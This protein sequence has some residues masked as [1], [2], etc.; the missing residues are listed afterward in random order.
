MRRV[1]AETRAGGVL[2]SSVDMLTQH[3]P[4]SEPPSAMLPDC[5]QTALERP[6]QPDELAPSY[7]FLASAAD[8]SPS[9]G[10][11]LPVLGGETIGG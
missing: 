9:T 1:A 4:Q 10:I 7:V 5:S 8:S 6:A 3:S 11:V 2:A